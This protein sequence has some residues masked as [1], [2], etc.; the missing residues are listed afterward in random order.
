MHLDGSPSRA[1][2]T[3]DFLRLSA[4]CALVNRQR[5]AA[6]RPRVNPKRAYR[7][8]QENHL[9]LFRHTGRPC[10]TRSHDGTI[11]VKRS[12][13]RWCSDGFEIACDNHEPVHIAFALD[14]TALKRP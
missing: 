11:V 14:C 13:Q 7:I 1:R 4:R 3:L 10:D 8:M 6:G 12:N 9:L 5:E 2:T